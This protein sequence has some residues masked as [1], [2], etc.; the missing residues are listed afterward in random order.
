M[1]AALYTI[2]AD[3]TAWK[4]F[5]WQHIITLR[6]GHTSAEV[7]VIP[8]TI[9]SIPHMFPCSKS[10]KLLL[11]LNQ[12]CANWHHIYFLWVCMVSILQ[13]LPCC[14]PHLQHTVCRHWLAVAI[15]CKLSETTSGERS[16][17]QFLLDFT[18]IL[19][20]WQYTHSLLLNLL[21]IYC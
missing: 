17:L 9:V 18:N 12:Q 15:S 14:L 2:F 1:N 11:S 16:K 19:H 20:I 13:M 4:E 21:I 6:H 5:S 8:W 7:C 10:S 3:T